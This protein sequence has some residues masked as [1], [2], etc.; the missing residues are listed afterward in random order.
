MVFM[1]TPRLILRNLA[2][3]DAEVMFDYRNSAV[4]SRYQRG[5]ARDYEG[6]AALIA[7]QKDSEMSA[8]APFM[9]AVALRETDEM[10]GEIVVKPEGGAFFLGYT[11]SYRYHR[12]G[13]AFE[14]LSALIGRLRA[15]RP[16]WNFI[17]YTEPENAASMG[18][19]RKLGYE[20]AGYRPA[21][22]ARVFVKRARRETIG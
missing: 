14:A 21:V 13:Y 17:S 10:V 9:L 8:D 20:D 16:D 6:I 1:E 7:R 11:I 5:Q 12:R 2:P 19:L 4:C 22:G 3:K 18:L 15:L